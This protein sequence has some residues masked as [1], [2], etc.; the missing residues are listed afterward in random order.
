MTDCYYNGEFARCMPGAFTA[1][2]TG[3]PV[4]AVKDR[5]CMG[6]GKT[7]PHQRR[8]N[9]IYYVTCFLPL[10]GKQV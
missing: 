2:E 1:E 3:V 4:R 7:L 8:L 10:L 6:M 9:I 5:R